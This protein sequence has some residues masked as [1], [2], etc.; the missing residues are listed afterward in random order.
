M[1]TASSNERTLATAIYVTSFF[2][3]LIGPLIIWLIKKEDSAFIDFHGKEY[4]NFFISYTV[5]SIVASL[6]MFILI[7]FILVPI[8]AILYIV[9]TIIAAVKAYN[10]EIYRIPLVFRILK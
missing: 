7:G 3:A 5:Y 1:D 10:G 2:S 9:F 8:I 4:L 6:M